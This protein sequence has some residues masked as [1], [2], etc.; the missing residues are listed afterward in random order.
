MVGIFHGYVKQPDATYQLLTIRGM[1]L[2]ARQSTTPLISSFWFGNWICV[3]SKKLGTSK[4]YGSWK[5]SWKLPC[6][7]RLRGR[8]VGVCS[9][10][11]CHVHPKKLR[12]AKTSSYC[13]QV[14]KDAIDADIGHL[15][16]SGMVQMMMIN[17]AVTAA[18][19]VK[20]LGMD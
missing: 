1:I 3:D 11:P 9:H 6:H 20:I 14:D 16:C 18:V 12:S 17:Q 7:W 19:L 15:G 8:H 13:P 5:L 4:S 2:Q 10:V